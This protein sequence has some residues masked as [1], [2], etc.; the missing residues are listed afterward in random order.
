MRIIKI[1]PT[2]FASA[3]NMTC[4]IEPHEECARC[5]DGSDN[6][7]GG[8]GDAVVL[9]FHKGSWWISGA[10]VSVA[11]GDDVRRFDE[12]VEGVR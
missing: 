6:P 4:V 10:S 7:D 9:Q 3:Y 2:Q 12:I 8:C 1:V 5:P 11:E